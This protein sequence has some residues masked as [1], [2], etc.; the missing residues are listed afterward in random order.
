MSRVVED[1]IEVAEAPQFE[2]KFH[3]SAEAERFGTGGNYTIT[4]DAARERPFIGE[5]VDVGPGKPAGPDG[6]LWVRELEGVISPEALAQAMSQFGH[7]GTMPPVEKG[8][9]IITNLNSI[10]YRL[11]GSSSKY[12]MRGDVCMAVVDRETYR[13]GP[14]QSYVLVC[15]NDERV[16]RCISKGDIWIPSGAMSTDDTPL[17]NKTIVA[18]YGDVVDRG[19]GVWQDGH[20]KEPPCHPGE[21]VLYDCSYNTLDITVRGEKRTLVHSDQIVKI[22]EGAVELD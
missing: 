1:F 13:V 7:R 22:V 4:G 19:P 21:L 6:A 17:V 12:L 16:R 14:L 3:L 10:S 5:V 9:I 2:A 15:A 8:Q 20:W 11:P 18:A